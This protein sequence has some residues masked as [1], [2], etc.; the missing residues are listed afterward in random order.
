MRILTAIIFIG[1]GILMANGIRLLVIH[2]YQ[3]GTGNLVCCALLFIAGAFAATY[4][5]QEAI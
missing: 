5:T 2:N 1:T 3:D 4:G